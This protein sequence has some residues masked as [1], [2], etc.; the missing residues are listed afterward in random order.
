MDQFEKILTEFSKKQF[1]FVSPYPSVSRR[2]LRATK[3]AL[4]AQSVEDINEVGLNCREFLNDYANQIHSPE[5]S[6]TDTK[7]GDTK[8]LLKD[9]IN[10]YTTSGGKRAVLDSLN[11]YVDK[12]VRELNTITHSSN[13][14]PEHAFLCINISISLIASIESLVLLNERENSPIYEYFGITKCPKCK[15]LKLKANS[16][17]DE[18]HDEMYYIVECQDCGW[19]D[20]TQ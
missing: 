18:Q 6:E 1:Q 5:Y 13:V 3:R 15:S 9:T 16:H 17:L 10:Y 8:Q 7:A 4:E 20:W 19:S 2:L 14:Y 12:V 11:T